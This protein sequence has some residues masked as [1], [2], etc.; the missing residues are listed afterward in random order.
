MP[1]HQ[2]PIV[3]LQIRYFAVA[4][5]VAGCDHE[6]IPSVPGETV[7]QLKARLGVLH[8]R[9]AA[10]L[11]HARIALHD[12]FCSQD[13]VIPLLEYSAHPA[14]AL[15][16]MEAICTEAVAQ[17]GLV[18]VSCL[19]RTGV[20]QVGEIAVAIAVAAPHRGE[21]FAACAYVIDE[22]KKR[23]PIW[24]KETTADGASWLGSTP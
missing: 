9:L 3:P 15:K 11:S 13:E 6:V 2:G 4:R 21:A 14:L 24:K 5:D 12:E 16:E 20:L 23:V 17:F 18:D 8:P 19:H 22:L 1:D 10:I 7:Q